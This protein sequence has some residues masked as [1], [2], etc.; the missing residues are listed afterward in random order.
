ME[1]W[2]R[3][4]DK[5]T[6]IKVEN[7]T[8][9]DGTGIKKAIEESLFGAFAKL[10]QVKELKDGWYINANETILGTYETKERALEVLDDIQNMLRF[11]KGEGFT[12]EGLISVENNLGIYQM[13][14]E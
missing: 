5:Y 6:L 12:G 9:V 4:Q 13:P 1:L 7:I 11:F 3:S 10:E 2:I 14:K 8:I